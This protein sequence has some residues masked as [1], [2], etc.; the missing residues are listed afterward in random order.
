MSEEKS[1]MLPDESLPEALPKTKGSSFF[2]A[3]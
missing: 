3:I 1:W 2:D